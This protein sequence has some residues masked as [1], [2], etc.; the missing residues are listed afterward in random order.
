MKLS[1]FARNYIS[2]FHNAPTDGS[3]S[4][5]VVVP[6]QTPEAATMD[7]IAA[8]LNPPP[9]DATPA[10]EGTE[11]PAEDPDSTAEAEVIPPAAQVDELA[12]LKA[13][14]AELKAQLSKPAEPAAAAPVQQPLP[15]TAAEATTPEQLTAYEDHVERMRDWAFANADGYTHT[16]GAGNTTEFTAEQMRETFTRYD[17]E[18]RRGIPN[19]ANELAQRTTAQEQRAAVEQ[20]AKTH[21]AWLNTPESPE[22]T[23][24]NQLAAALPGIAELPAGPMLLGHIVAGHL[25]LTAKTAAP[26]AVQTP[27]PR[28]KPPVVPGGA[29]PGGGAHYDAT[30]ALAKIRA[31]GG[32]KQ[33]LADGLA[34]LL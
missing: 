9:A 27:A 30:E 1:H 29:A 31:A 17:R 22:A 26:A 7:G 14:L 15:R 6:P 18:L 5:T 13:E 24:Y 16:D 4:P 12:T 8:L 3:A 34:G 2:V 10:T 28:P 23:L 20:H 32:S 11:A 21:Y 25:A 33:A 19:R